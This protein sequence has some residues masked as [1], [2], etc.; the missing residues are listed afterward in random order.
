MYS[1]AGY[2]SMIADKIRVEA[3]AAALRQCVQPGAIV[4]EIGTGPGVFAVLACQLGAGRVYAIEPDD[5]IELAREIARANG[6]A[7]RIEFIQAIS[8]E[9]NLEKKADVIVSDLRSVLPLFQKHIPSILDARRR[10]LAP[11]G[12]LIPRKDAIWA[13]IVEIPEIYSG[14]V[15]RWESNVLGQDLN[16]ARRLAVNC[17]Q[18]ARA[19]PEHLLVKPQCWAELDYAT[20]EDPNVRRRLNWTVER[21]GTGHGFL[22]WF[23]AEL[24]DGIG[25]SNAP[26]APEAIYGSM[27][28]PWPQPVALEA[29]QEVQADLAAQFIGDDYIWRWSTRIASSDHRDE[30]VAHFDQSQ[31]AGAVI[32]MDGL[33]RTASDYVPRISEEGRVHRRTLELMDGNAS[34]EAIACRLASEFPRRFENWRQALSYA[35]V[36]SREYSL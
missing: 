9:V 25:F 35:G 31:L 4:V 20:I 8:T 26:G 3:Y 32:S 13:A 10:L 27:L 1:L 7:D 15:N 30:V 2:G 6:C 23:D 28:L 34:L 36:R 24:A 11:G 17:D 33:R 22:V 19:K 18:K 16:A 5:I 21:A 29:G 12:T 14:I